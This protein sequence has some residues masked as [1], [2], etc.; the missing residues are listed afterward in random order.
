MP[1]PLWGGGWKGN[2]GKEGDAHKSLTLITLEELGEEKLKF[3]S[4]WCSKE[5]HVTTERSLDSKEAI[6]SLPC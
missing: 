4:C 5:V 6:F 2:H 3:V 1:M